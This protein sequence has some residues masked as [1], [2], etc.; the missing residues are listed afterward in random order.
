MRK[1]LLLFTTGGTHWGTGALPT[2]N[3]RLYTEGTDNQSDRGATGALSTV[4]CRLYTEGTD[5][6]SDRGP[7]GHCQLSTVGY[8]Q[9]AQT[10][11]QTGGHWGTVNCQL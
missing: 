3:C 11:S 4:N 5:N 1:W 7:L 2:L 9:R 6:Q 10:T 8:I